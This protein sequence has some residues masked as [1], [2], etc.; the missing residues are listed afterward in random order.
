M[1]SDLANKINPDAE[2]ASGVEKIEINESESKHQPI[3]VKYCETCHFPEE[4]CDFSHAILFKKV[5]SVVVEEKKEEKKEGEVKIEEVK[6]EAPAKVDKKKGKEQHIL[7]ELS[8]RGK[9]KH[10]TYV[11]NLEKFGLNLKDVAKVFS[12]K[13]ACSSTVTKEDNGQEGITLTGEFG[14]EI[15]D[16]LVE[17]YPTIK[18]EMCKVKEPKQTGAGA[19]AEIK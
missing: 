13:F 7:I 19:P 3:V 2:I 6:T 11:F 8:K 14:Y 5:Q 16:F 17:K 18:P 1:S 15:V 9:K 12:K 4:F 10:V